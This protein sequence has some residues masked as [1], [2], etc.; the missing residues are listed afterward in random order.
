[1]SGKKIVVL[2]G[3]RGTEEVQ[4]GEKNAVRT[5]SRSQTPYRWAKRTL[6]D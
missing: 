5:T 6:C 4:N 3:V 2:C 1:M